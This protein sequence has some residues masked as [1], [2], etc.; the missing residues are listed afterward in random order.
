MTTVVVTAIFAAVFGAIVGLIWGYG[1]DVNVTSGV[2]I[3]ALIGAAFGLLVDFISK[4]ARSQSN[5]TQQSA[6]KTNGCIIGGLAMVTG[7]IGIVVWA[8]RT[9]FF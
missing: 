2:K 6:E 5:I 9:M 8:V 7:A 3:G 1:L 4:V